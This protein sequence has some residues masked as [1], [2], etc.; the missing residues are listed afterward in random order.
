MKILF[1]MCVFVFLFGSMGAFA[2]GIYLEKGSNGFGGEVRVILSEDGF[3]ATKVAAGYSIAGI[4]DIGAGLT[5]TPGEL[6]GYS[7]SDIRIAFDYRV[8][9]LKQ[10]VGVPLSLQI[11]GSY[12]FNDVTS[13][14]L[15]D[16]NATRRG[17]GYTIG[18]NVARNFRVARF[19]LLHINLLVDYESTRYTNTGGTLA[20]EDHIGNLL[21]GGGGG[22]LYEFSKGQTLAIRAEVRADEDLS[23]QIH[24]VIGIAFPQN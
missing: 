22:F 3:E 2:Q 18:L 7:S 8:N 20:P 13:A 5:Y 12:G 6:E 9:V 14:Y 23:L 11:V 17:T 16:N 1:L 19:L 15:D 24:P 4:L 10:S 21:Y